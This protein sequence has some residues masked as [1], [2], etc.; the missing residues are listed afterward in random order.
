M[1]VSNTGWYLYNFRLPLA[2]F[3]RQS[4]AE[5]VLC[6]PNDAYVE[7]MTAEGF[8]WVEL[9]MRRASINPFRELMT[10]LYLVWIYRSVRPQAVHHFTIKC[11][12]YGTIAA[13]LTGIRSVVNAITG[14]GHTFI[15][16]TLKSRLL[17]PALM[18]LYKRILTARRVQVI[19]QNPDDIAEFAD[20][21][22]ILPEKTVLIR[23]SGVN[24]TRFVPRPGALD[25]QPAPMVLFAGR[26]IAEKG[27]R[28]FVEAARLLK[29]RGVECNFT[30]AGSADPGNP[31]SLTAELETWRKEGLVDLVGHVE[32][33]DDLIAQSSVVVLPSYREG[34]PR[35]LVEAAAMGKPMVAT[36]VPGCREVVRDGQNGFLVEV[37][38]AH[39]LASAIERLLADSSLRERMGV[40]SREIAQEFCERKVLKETAAVYGRTGISLQVLESGKHRQ[41]SLN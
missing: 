4:G 2:R 40:A 41:L 21:H 36:D 3:L 5:V 18:F 8:Q 28:E 19:F 22:L 20:R 23:S 10:L 11:V 24:L 12:I 33:L 25:G 26:L 27:L 13:K 34:T 38:N 16:T 29:E 32:P 6:S 15:G 30:V 39:K 1:L 9:P 14:L 35:V 37:R 7:R 31:S 17:R